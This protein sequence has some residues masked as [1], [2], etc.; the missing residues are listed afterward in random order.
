MAIKLAKIGYYSGDPEQVLGAPVDVVQA[1]LDY[2]AFETDY[3]SEYIAQR[4]PK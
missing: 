1:I 2:E 3:E 4:K